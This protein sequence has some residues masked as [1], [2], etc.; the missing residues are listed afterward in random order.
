[1]KI[2]ANMAAY[3]TDCC[4]SNVQLQGRT[5][6]GYNIKTNG[7][8]YNDPTYGKVRILASDTKFKLYSIIKVTD[9]IEGT[10]YAIILDRGDK[11]IGINRLYLFDLVVESQEKA[12]V[13]YG[14]HK[15]VIFEV[16]R[17]GK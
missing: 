12:R 15:N 4:S 9:E 3:G 6:S 8:Y 14:V 1:M 2:N 11:N 7:I 13:E 17:V 10:Y 5:A 16:I